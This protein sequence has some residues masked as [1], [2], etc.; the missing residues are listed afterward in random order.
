MYKLKEEQRRFTSYKPFHGVSQSPIND[1]LFSIE[2]QQITC[3]ARKCKRNTISVNMKGLCMRARFC[4]R[5]S[6][7]VPRICTR[8]SCVCLLACDVRAKV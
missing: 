7:R 8:T 5:E 3:F 1:V 6:A 4:T 2:G